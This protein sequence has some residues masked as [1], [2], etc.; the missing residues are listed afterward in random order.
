MK[1]FNLLYLRLDSEFEIQN[2]NYK[3]KTNKDKLV[4][5]FYQNFPQSKITFVAD[6]NS[7]YNHLFSQDA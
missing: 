4:S 3:I 5:Y 1:L 6:I 7:F 2:I